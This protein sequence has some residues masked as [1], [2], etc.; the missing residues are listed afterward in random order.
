MPE[1]CKTGQRLEPTSDAVCLPQP[2]CGFTIEAAQKT[3]R[4]SIQFRW[5]GRLVERD[6]GHRSGSLPL[7]DRKSSISSLS[8]AVRYHFNKVVYNVA[9]LVISSQKSCPPL[10]VRAQN[11]NNDTTTDTATDPCW[12]ARFVLLRPPPAS[13]DPVSQPRARRA[14]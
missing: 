2:D 6:Q 1:R 8:L 10:A 9:L 4:R 14:L 5:M 7:I 11:N 13:V 12:H 3:V